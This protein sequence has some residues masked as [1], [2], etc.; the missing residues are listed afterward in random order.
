MKKFEGLINANAEKR[1]KHFI[2]TVSDMGSVW[3]LSNEDGY[4]TIDFDG[5]IHLLVWPSREF[6]VA[7][8]SND[9][10]VEVE[11]HEFFER[12]KDLDIH[13]EIRFMVFPNKIDAYI[14]DSQG[15]LKDILEELEKIE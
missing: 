12:C 6:A 8:D 11:I 7:F 2:S 15:L 10:P 5:Y 13:K 9:Y 3:L 4:Y 1:Y 14:I